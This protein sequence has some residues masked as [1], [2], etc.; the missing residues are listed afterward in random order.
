MIVLIAVGGMLILAGLALGIA[1]AAGV[2]MPQ[3]TSPGS[4][5]AA[6]TSRWLR[7]EYLIAVAVGIAAMLATGWVAAGAG[8]AAVVVMAPAM[9]RPSAASTRHIARLEALASWTRR[10]ADLL[11][12]GAAQTMQDAL[13]RTAAT[14]PPPIAAE[15]AALASRMGPRGLEPALRQ[16]AKDIDDPV[17]DHVTMALIVRHRAGGRGLADV[18]AALATDV[19]EQVRMR[20]AILSEQTKQIS[21][22]RGILAVTVGFWVL[23]AIFAHTYMAP[24]NTVAG[25]LALAVIVAGFGFTLAWFRRLAQPVVGARFLEDVDTPQD[26]DTSSLSLSR[27]LR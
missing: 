26:G 8:A 18:L 3:R 16:F 14:S 10:L 24:Y 27:G 7:R 15:T 5:D 17:G 11:A 6:G 25:Q 23:L 12:S 22:V 1:L 9:L 19:D 21:S 4:A 2:Q 20:R 13:T